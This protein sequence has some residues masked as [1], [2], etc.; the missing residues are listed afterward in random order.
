MCYLDPQLLEV[1]DA[2]KVVMADQ[3]TNELVIAAAHR[4]E[5][6]L[7]DQPSMH[8]LAGWANH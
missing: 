7:M 1:P 6:S 4:I 2:L 5:Q 3:L 8:V